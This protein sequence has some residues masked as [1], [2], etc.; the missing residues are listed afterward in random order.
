M[1]GVLRNLVYD[2]IPAISNLS[3]IPGNIKP[4]PHF[5]EQFPVKT[6]IIENESLCEE[7]ENNIRQAGPHS[8]SSAKCLMTKLNMHEEHDSFITVGDYAIKLAQSC[9]VA[10]RTTSDGKKEV[11]PLRLKETWGLLYI[12]GNQANIHNHWPFLWSYT[13]CVKAGKCCTPLRFPTAMKE[14]AIVPEIGQLIVFPAYIMH[15]VHEHTCDHERIMISGNLE[16]DWDS[17]WQRTI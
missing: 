11:V 14:L 13:Y 17:Q 10:K 7:L 1:S 9:P 12:K 5:T 4:W 8:L 16:V 6:V 15:E 2:I 3:L